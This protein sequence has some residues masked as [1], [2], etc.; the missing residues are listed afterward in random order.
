MGL[1]ARQGAEGEELLFLL[2]ARATEGDDHAAEL[3]RRLDHPV[4]H[5][6]RGNQKGEDKGTE[7]NFRADPF[8]MGLSLKQPD[9]RD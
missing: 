2:A 9:S 5:L 8:F 3:D 1:C 7:L 4:V 6:E